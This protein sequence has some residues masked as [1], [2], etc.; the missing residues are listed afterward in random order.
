[1]MKMC[2]FRKIHQISS[3]STQTPRNRHRTH[4]T[5]IPT[6]F[7]PCRA[8]LRVWSGGNLVGGL[9]PGCRGPTSLLTFWPPL[10]VDICVT[11]DFCDED[12]SHFYARDSNHTARVATQ[13]L[14]LR[15]GGVKSE[16]NCPGQK[17]CH[18]QELHAGA[19]AFF[20]KTHFHHN[21]PPRGPSVQFLGVANLL[22]WAIIL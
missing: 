1:M 8:A 16:N 12:N 6:H 4:K 20:E 9:P 11:F 22:P 18:T 7:L 3:E 15:F 5:H 21:T 17:I 2:F 14:E 10:A 19:C 13:A